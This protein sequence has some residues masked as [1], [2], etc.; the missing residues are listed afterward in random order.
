MTLL[1]TFVLREFGDHAWKSQ[2]PLSSLDSTMSCV[3]P[4]PLASVRSFPCDLAGKRVVAGDAVGFPGEG[5]SFLL[6]PPRQAQ[7]GERGEED[8]AE[9]CRHQVVEDGVDCWADVEEDVCQ[10]VEV[11]VEVVKETGRTEE[12]QKSECEELKA[13]RVRKAWA[14]FQLTFSSCKHEF[15]GAWATTTLLH[16]QLVKHGADTSV[17]ILP[18][19]PAVR[20]FFSP[21]ARQDIHLLH[22]FFALEIGILETG[23][24]D[25]NLLLC[26][27]YTLAW[28]FWLQFWSTE[29][30]EE[31][32]SSNRCSSLLPLAVRAESA[33]SMGPWVGICP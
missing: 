1:N 32:N 17:K 22:S 27:T 10:H 26:H 3:P 11:V 9:V 28:L 4:P 2:R 14:A 31:P 8:L 12:R 30:A 15:S 29:V 18:R 7:N 13:T 16:P 6:L 25:G 5:Q 21:G 19:S 33:H 20:D 24:P 23:K